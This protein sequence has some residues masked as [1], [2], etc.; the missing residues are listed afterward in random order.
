ML[1]L[2]PCSWSV[3]EQH[4][5]VFCRVTRAS[6]KK[7]HAV[8]WCVVADGERQMSPHLGFDLSDPFCRKVEY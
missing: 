1:C 6:R 3:R 7:D 5:E 8:G 2:L 4:H